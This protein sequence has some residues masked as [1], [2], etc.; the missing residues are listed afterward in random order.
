MRYKE[1]DCFGE[2]ALKNEA[3]RSATVWTLEDSHFAVLEKEY[4]NATF[5]NVN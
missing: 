3:K 5:K 4:F 2:L 1:G